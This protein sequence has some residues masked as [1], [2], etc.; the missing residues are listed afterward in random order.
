RQPRAGALLAAGGRRPRR[1]RQRR[2][3]GAADRARGGA[4]PSHGRLQP[5]WI[6]R[7]RGAVVTA[8]WERTLD[9]I[10]RDWLAR[11]G[12]ALRA[13]RLPRAA[14]PVVLSAVARDAAAAGRPTLVLCPGPARAIA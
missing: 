1:D 14:W 9:G 11:P 7:L 4:D 12:A 8:L 10:L 2:G 6:S 13:G 3:R 5:R